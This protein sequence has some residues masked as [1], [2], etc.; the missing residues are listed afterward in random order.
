MDDLPDIADLEPG[1]EV[2]VDYRSKRS[3]NVIEREGEVAHTEQ[4][5]DAEPLVYIHDE[6]RGFFSHTFV[7]LSKG[8]TKSGDDCI[9][10]ISLTTEPETDADQRPK[11]STVYPVEHAVSHVSTLGVVKKV[12]RYTPGASMGNDVL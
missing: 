5:A 1:D 4:T 9:A 8:E 7:V 2:R 11:V 6:E 12:I 10:A 3:G